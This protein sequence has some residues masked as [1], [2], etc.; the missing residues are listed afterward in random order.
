MNDEFEFIENQKGKRSLIRNGH[1]YN[2]NVTNRNESTLWRCVN[3]KICSASITKD[4]NDQ[5]IL[6]ESCHVCE[7]NIVSNEVCKSKAVL[8][9][10]VCENLGSVRK[11]VEEH[12]SFQNARTQSENFDLIPQFQSIKDTLYRARKKFLVTDLLA[13]N[14]TQSVTIPEVLAKDFLVCEDQEKIFVFSTKTARRFMKKASSYYADGTFR[15][16]PKPFYQLYVL[17]IDCNSDTKSTNIVPVVF[18][19]LPNKSEWTYTRLFQLIKDNF[20]MAI[21][22]FKCDYE[23]AQINAI[24]SVFPDVSVSGCYHHYNEAIWRYSKKKKN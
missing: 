20:K 14:D 19:L 5:C 13:Y 11:I 18:A 24:S 4:K 8:K 3:R 2:Y 7:V 12:N 15:V 22:S 23:I 10:A 1:R 16:C 9:N 17:H 6:K 21:T